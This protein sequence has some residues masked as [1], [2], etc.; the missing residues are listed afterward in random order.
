MSKKQES[1]KEVAS[2]TLNYLG[3]DFKKLFLLLGILVLI[4]V[5]LVLVDKKTEFLAKFAHLL[6]IK[7]VGK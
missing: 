6:M 4:V 2:P 3:K 7:L 1:Q 5:I